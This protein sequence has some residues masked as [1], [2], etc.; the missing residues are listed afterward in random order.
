MNGPFHPAATINRTVW[1][2]GSVAACPRSIPEETPI[3]FSYNRTTHAVMLA[4]PDDM[5]D[6]AVGFSLSEGIIQRKEDIEA[7]DIVAGSRGIERRMDLAQA[8]FDVLTRRQRRLAGPGSC[9][10][11]VSTAWPRLYVPRR[12]SFPTRASR[13]P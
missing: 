9:A 7:L 5:E 8:P 11:A 3:A 1:H 13:Q 6:F 12:R 2:G 4:T 10:C